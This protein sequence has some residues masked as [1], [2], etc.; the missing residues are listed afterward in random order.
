MTWI[1][2]FAVCFRSFPYEKKSRGVVCLYLFHSVCD[3]CLKPWCMHRDTV[4]PQAV[5]ALSVYKKISL[6]RVVQSNP[7]RNY[8]ST[9]KATITRCDLSATILFKL[10]DSYV[11]AF[12]FAQ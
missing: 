4:S 6:K 5:S 10:V 2:C 11:V 7:S 3:C 8:K 9:V 12:K 1:T